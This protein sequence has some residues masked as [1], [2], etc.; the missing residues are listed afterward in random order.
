MWF[1]LQG[2]TYGLVVC[3]TQRLAHELAGPVFTVAI[4]GLQTGDYERHVDVVCS[5]KTADYSSLENGVGRRL[6]CCIGSLFAGHPIDIYTLITDPGK[7]REITWSK[8]FTVEIAGYSHAIRG[9]WGVTSPASGRLD[10][11]C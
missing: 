9:V 11:C 6:V 1:R 4:L 10:R 8:R 7:R 3:V 5:G 2:E